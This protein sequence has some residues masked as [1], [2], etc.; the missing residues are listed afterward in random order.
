LALL[1]GIFFAAHIVTI[2]RFSREKDPILITI[3]QFLFAGIFASVAVFVQEP[4]AIELAQWGMD[5]WMAVGYLAILATAV[6]LLLQN[7]GQKYTDANS[8]AIILGTESLFCVLFGVIFYGEKITT[9]LAIGFV[10]IF[11]AIIVSETKLKF[12]RR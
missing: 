2:E 3:L 8:A 11:A 10:L 6:A 9:M 7:I 4:K 5:L 1:S 12:L